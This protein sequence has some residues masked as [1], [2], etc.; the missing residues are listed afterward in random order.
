M[1]SDTI[2][3]IID[4]EYQKLHKQDSP[5]KTLTIAANA[6]L[7]ATAGS[8]L[9]GEELKRYNDYRK[10]QAKMGNVQAWQK[11]DRD[12]IVRPGSGINLQVTDP[13]RDLT[14]AMDTVTVRA[15]TSSGDVLDAFVLTE[16]GAHTGIFTGRLKTSLSFPVV[17]ASDTEEGVDPHAIINSTKNTPWKSDVAKKGDRWINVD[18]M[19]SSVF[20]TVT[21][22]SPDLDGIAK[23]VMTGELD[24]A[25]RVLGFMP[26][27]STGD[28]AGRFLMMPPSSRE[29]RTFE[30]AATEYAFRRGRGIQ[31]QRNDHRNYHNKTVHVQMQVAIALDAPQEFSFAIKGHHA[32]KAELLVDGKKIQPLSR[33]TDATKMRK[34]APTKLTQGV[35]E[36]R[37]SF[38]A[39]PRR[40]EDPG[41]EPAGVGHHGREGVRTLAGQLVQHQEAS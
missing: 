7:I 11:Q 34:Y 20:D 36:I 35:H 32:G 24:Q 33:S 16:T 39:S 30:T 14:D 3:Y 5:A 15:T 37:Y 17:T 40:R 13:D 9:T 4:P 27:V 31:W 2:S 28:I 38:T 22:K 41:H 29:G 1:G 26:T 6:K 23:I 10:A 12:H 21:L 8:I 19:S 25:P 18:T